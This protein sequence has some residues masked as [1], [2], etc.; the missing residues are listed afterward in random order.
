MDNK[1]LLKLIFEVYKQNSEI[2]KEIN[3][4]KKMINN[5]SVINESTI[6]KA[7][8]NPVTKNPLL[9]QIFEDIEPLNE[10][11][12]TSILDIADNHDY[13]NDDPAGR[14]MNMIKTKDFKK[15]LNAMDKLSNPLKH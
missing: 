9:S 10:S 4:L 2:K 11:E 7:K 15:T 5:N 1:K 6:K 13:N 14:I 12:T 8:V 3:D